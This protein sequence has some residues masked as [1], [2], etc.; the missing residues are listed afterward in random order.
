MLNAGNYIKLFKVLLQFFRVDESYS[1]TVRATLRCELIG[2]RVCDS[3][4]AVF[5]SNRE[6]LM[7]NWTYIEVNQAR[8]VS[9]L[10]SKSLNSTHFTFRNYTIQISNG[11]P[12]GDNVLSAVLKFDII[13]DD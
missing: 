10:R 1:M 8:A 13:S 7:E 6:G 4:S 5:T 12:C 2:L 3:V 9:G 11:R